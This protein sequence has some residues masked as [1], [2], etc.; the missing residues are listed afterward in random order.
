MPVAPLM[1]VGPRIEVKAVEGDALRSHR[2][3]HHARTHLTVESV[4]I[5]AE[6]RRRVAQPDEAGNDTAGRCASYT[7]VRAAPCCMAPTFPRGVR[8]IT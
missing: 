1:V 5:H 2:D 8:A 3:G 4:L 6:I 7:G